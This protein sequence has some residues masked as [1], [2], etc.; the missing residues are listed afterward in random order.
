[1]KATKIFIMLAATAAIS[2]AVIGVAYG[3]YVTNQTNVNAYSHYA[4]NDDFW[5]WFGGC[6]GFR[7]EPNG[8]QYQYQHPSNGTTQPPTYVPPQQ[9]YQPYQPQYP[10]QGHY[11]YGYGHGCWGW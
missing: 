6:L 7:P 4:S 11:A 1:M 3:Y 5:G 8:Y 9:P 10:N 2:L